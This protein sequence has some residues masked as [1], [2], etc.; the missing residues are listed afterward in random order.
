[1]KAV[2]VIS[3]GKVEVVDL[4]MPAMAAYECLV[5]VTA[6][7]LCNSTDLKIIDGEIGAMT[8]PYPV[9]LGHEGVG[10][11]V[12][13][14]SK[15]RN[16]QVGDR[17]LNPYGRIAPGTPYQRMWACMMEYAIVQDGE[18]M[19]EIGSAKGDYV[20]RKQGLLPA[21]IPPQ[22][23]GVL[24]TL[25]E[26]YSGV[27]NFGVAPGFEVLVYGDGPVGLGLCAFC[28]R[29]GARWVGCVGHHPHRLEKIGRLGRADV[30]IN[31]HT[32]D[33]SAVVG[34]RKLDLVIDAVGSVAII[35]EG[36][37]LLKPGG[38]IGAYGV[39]KKKYADLN[40]VELPNNVN[41]HMLNFPYQERAVQDELVAMILKGELNPKD[42]Y[43]HVLP[44]DDAPRAVEMVRKRAAFKV[45]FK[46]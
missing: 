21:E 27:R 42:F 22:D 3:P 19:D 8:V 14:G 31:S 40:L 35:K 38:T 1:M 5:R 43:S 6:S 44:I 32:Q 16:W 4:P 20:F 13:I 26:V 2:A 39:L 25:M 33:V 12:E 37:V 36:A 45:V 17:M 23:C 9:I 41:L 30:L 24:L 29:Q 10:E 28:R 11:V 34:D 7:G 15:V 46:T 18:V